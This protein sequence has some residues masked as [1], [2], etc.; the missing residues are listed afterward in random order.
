G[1]VRAPRLELANE[2][3]LRTHIHAEWLAEVGL[4]LGASI[5]ETI[6]TARCPELPL[7]ENARRQID[8]SPQRRRAVRDRVMDA[9]KD[10]LIA[11]QQTTWWSEG[12][13]NQVLERAA[14]QFDRAFDRWRE[15]Y[16]AAQ[17][18][19][20]AARAEEDRA[21]DREARDQAQRRQNEARR[22]LDLLLQRDVQFE[23]SDFYPYRDLAVEGFL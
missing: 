8:L 21:R 22:Q 12:W 7:N 18:Q 19:L 20:E 17:Q 6:D 1:S 10:D 23:E 13:L 16:R 14:E 3:L 2:A 4:P 5:A 9:L 11:L 15:L